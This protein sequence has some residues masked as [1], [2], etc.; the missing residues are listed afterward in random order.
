M[1]AIEGKH[2]FTKMS[3]ALFFKDEIIE[4]VLLYLLVPVYLYAYIKIADY[5]GEYFF[6]YV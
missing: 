6:I 4:T 1:F 2:G 3:F 5:G